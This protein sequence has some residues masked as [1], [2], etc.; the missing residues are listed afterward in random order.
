MLKIE[1]KPKKKT[2][3]RGNE[4][5]LGFTDDQVYSKKRNHMMLWFL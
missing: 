3:T 5:N 4:S 1:V 2:F